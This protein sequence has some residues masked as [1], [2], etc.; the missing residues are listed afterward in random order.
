M[1]VVKPLNEFIQ[2]PHNTLK[3]CQAGP[4]EIS[5]EE[6]S[7]VIM[8]AEYLRRLLADT[9]LVNQLDEIFIRLKNRKGI[10]ENKIT[11]ILEHEWESLKSDETLFVL[12]AVHGKQNYWHNMKMRVSPWN[13]TKWIWLLIKI[14]SIVF[15]L[16]LRFYKPAST[17]SSIKYP[18]VTT[19]V[20]W[21]LN[22]RFFLQN[23]SRLHYDFS[24]I[25]CSLLRY[26][27]P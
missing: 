14:Y 11:G 23:I 4:I 26:A 13:P 3:E 22:P 17:E 12:D 10:S 19:L 21:E 16:N 25:N 15:T 27:M 5:G 1:S 18:A 20:C 9:F 6:Q 7:Y 2:K 8:T 24:I